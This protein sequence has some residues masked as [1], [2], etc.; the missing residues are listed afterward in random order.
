MIAIE[1]YRSRLIYEENV[2]LQLYMFV[3]RARRLYRVKYVCKREYSNELLKLTILCGEM[4]YAYPIVNNLKAEIILFSLLKND[5]DIVVSQ[6]SEEVTSIKN[7][8]SY[9][10][11]VYLYCN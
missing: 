5:V 1:V 2:N 6:F 9:T 4:R 8:Y 11:Y 10:L 3:G 7:R